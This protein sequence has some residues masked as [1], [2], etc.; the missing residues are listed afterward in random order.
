[1]PR[2][3][4]LRRFLWRL[5]RAFAIVAAALGPGKPPPP[6]PQEDVDDDGQVDPE[7]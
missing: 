1:M 4:R 2:S 5:A 6:P 7:D 3:A